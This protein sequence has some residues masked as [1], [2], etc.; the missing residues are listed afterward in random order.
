MK[1]GVCQLCRERRDLVEG[2]VWPRFAYK[3]YA[4]NRET[5]GSFLELGGLK[6]SNR[7]VKRNWFC[8]ACDRDVLGPVEHYA[9]QFCDRVERAPDRSHEYDER[10]LR[11]AAS[12]SWRVAKF[13]ME[14]PNTRIANDIL[15][16]PCKRWKDHMLADN[17]DLRPYSQ[18]LFFVFDREAGLHN[19]LGGGPLADENLILSQVGPLFVVGLLGRKQLSLADIEVWSR[20]QLF[21]EGGTVAPITEWR[22]GDCITKAFLRVLQGHSSWITARVDETRRRRERAKVM[23]PRTGS[24]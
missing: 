9:A 24:A 11:F 15:R 14:R 23:K 3:K 4:S 17:V 19:G 18:H 2:H 6:L 20:S 8:Q 5:G 10:L 13:Y 12:I 7:Q 21:A 22:V 16:K 1:H